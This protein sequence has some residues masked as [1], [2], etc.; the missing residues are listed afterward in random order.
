MNSGKWGAKSP[1]QEKIVTLEAQLK[2]LKYLK[3]SAQLANKLN[4]NQCQGPNQRK[5]GANAGENQRNN[6]LANPQLPSH[7]QAQHF[8][9]SESHLLTHLPL[10]T[11]PLPLMDRAPLPMTRTPITKPTSNP[12]QTLS[13][14][15]ST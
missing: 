13:S 7:G 9:N 5:D 14:L 2:E 12:L 15:P 11:Q 4:Q 8:R 3:L 6:R 1:N 10:G